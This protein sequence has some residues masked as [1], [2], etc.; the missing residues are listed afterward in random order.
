MSLLLALV[1]FAWFMALNL[2]VLVYQQHNVALM[3]HL[4][5][6]Y[7]SIYKHISG[8]LT[9]SVLGTSRQLQRLLQNIG[10]AEL[11]KDPLIK[12][13]LI[14]MTAIRH[15]GLRTMGVMTLLLIVVGALTFL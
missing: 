5:T 12:D 2:F 1:A 15:R 6:N 10:D 11:L 9:F 7:P 13:V 3:A 4:R 8:R 14:E